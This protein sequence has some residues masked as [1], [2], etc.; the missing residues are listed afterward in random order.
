M[1]AII[2]C[3]CIS[4]EAVIALLGL[5]PSMW[6]LPAVCQKQKQRVKNLKE[7]RSTAKFLTLV[8]L[9]NLSKWWVTSPLNLTVFQSWHPLLAGR[10]LFPTHFQ[11][12]RV[13]VTMTECAVRDVSQTDLPDNT[14]RSVLVGCFPPQSLPELSTDAI[15]FVFLPLHFSSIAVPL[16]HMKLFFFGMGQGISVFQASGDYPV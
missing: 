1:F 2:H 5:L 9:F 3:N 16:M 14:F 6:Q 11:E 13:S 10:V 4:N 12:V 8:S 15:K 7:I